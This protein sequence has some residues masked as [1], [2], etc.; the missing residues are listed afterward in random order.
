MFLSLLCPLP[1]HGEGKKKVEL[2]GISAAAGIKRLGKCHER[3]K[4]MIV[5]Q[6]SFGELF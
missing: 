5:A 2:S 3:I 1:A 6:I 4:Q